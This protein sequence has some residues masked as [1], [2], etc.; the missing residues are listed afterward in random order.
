MRPKERRET[1][2]QDRFLLTARP[3]HQP[4]TC[5]GE[6]STG[7]RLAVFGGAVRR[8]LHRPERSCARLRIASPAINRAASAV[9]QQRL[10]R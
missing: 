7:D 10:K 8:V 5:A 3:D 4:G 9:S 6:A 2:E 1:G